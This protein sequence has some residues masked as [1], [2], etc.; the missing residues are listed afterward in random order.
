MTPERRRHLKREGKAEVVSR[1]HA[2]KV[3]SEAL[4]PD[5]LAA[6][7]H[8]GQPPND[9]SK[10]TNDQIARA[11]LEAWVAAERPV[12][13]RDR[14]HQEFVP[15]PDTSQKWKSHPFSYLL[16]KRCGSALPSH[17]VS[18]LFQR[19]SCQCGNIRRL[20][21]FGKAWLRVQ[22]KPMLLPVVIFGRAAPSGA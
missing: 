1:S 8:T 12:L 15:L 16:C 5:M 4:L 21:L 3:A 10:L 13:H 6:L 17:P 2:R 19:S 9:L 11:R 20:Q 7:S 14:L 22:Q 18:S